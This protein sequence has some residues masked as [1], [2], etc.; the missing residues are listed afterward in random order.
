MKLCLRLLI[1]FVTFCG[2]NSKVLILIVDPWDEDIAKRSVIETMRYGSLSFN[3]TILQTEVV[4]F[5]DT[6]NIAIKRMIEINIQIGL[7]MIIDATCEGLGFVRITA[8]KNK[9]P[10]IIVKP[11]VTEFIKAAT[12]VLKEIGGV[13]AAFVFQNEAEMEHGLCH[14][15]EHVVLRILLIDGMTVNTTSKL[16]GLR[17]RHSNYVMLGTGQEVESML[18]QV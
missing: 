1:I 9:I 14:V 12:D 5:T 11:A 13:D 2:I 8:T 16:G 10:Y 3:N 6:N 18:Y 17:P 7:S 15:V 4:A